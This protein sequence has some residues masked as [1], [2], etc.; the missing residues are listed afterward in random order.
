MEN[1][2]FRSDVGNIYVGI[3]GLPA[4]DEIVA[5]IKVVEGE[6]MT[7]EQAIKAAKSAGVYEEQIDAAIREGYIE[8]AEAFLDE[9]LLYVPEHDSEEQV[10]KA[11][12]EWIAVKNCET[13]MEEAIRNRRLFDTKGQN[14]LDFLQTYDDYRLK[15]WTPLTF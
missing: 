1:R 2:Q 12:S 7:R 13:V 5:A 9:P 11:I 6:A 15:F 3:A 8:V 4:D 10:K 14:M